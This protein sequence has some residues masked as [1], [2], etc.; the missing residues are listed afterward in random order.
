MLQLADI[1]CA[2]AGE[3]AQQR[4]LAGAVAANESDAFADLDAQLGPI[5]QR[6]IA[7]GE[8]AVK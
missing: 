3:H 1:Q 6:V 4:G 7:K 2:D 8:L 5:E